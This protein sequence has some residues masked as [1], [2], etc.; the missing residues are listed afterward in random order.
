MAREGVAVTH[1]DFP[2]G[3]LEGLV[4]GG[5]AVDEEQGVGE[6]APDHGGEH[7]GE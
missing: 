1:V 6:E 4:R 3:P 5:A 2:V 7:A